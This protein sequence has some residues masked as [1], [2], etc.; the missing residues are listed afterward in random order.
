MFILR[1][2]VLLLTLTLTVFSTSDCTKYPNHSS[3][4]QKEEKEEEVVVQSESDQLLVFIDEMHDKHGFDKKYLISIFADVSKE[5]VEK[6]GNASMRAIPR[7][8]FNWYAYRDNMVNNRRTNQGIAYFKK[9]KD[10]LVEAEKRFGVPSY[11]VVSILGVETNYGTVRMRYNALEA[12]YALSFIETRR[13][14]YFKKELESFLVLSK[15][16]NQDPTLFRSSYAGA[17]GIPQFMP[18]NIEKYGIDGD[19]DGY[20]DIIN[21]HKDAIFS[22]ANYLSSYGWKKGDP[23]VEKVTL[24]SSK[25]KEYSKYFSG[26]ACKSGKQYS[27]GKLK[28]AGVIFSKSTPIDDDKKGKLLRVGIGG[29]RSEYYVVFDNLCVIMRYNNSIGYSMAVNYLGGKIANK[30]NPNTR[31]FTGYETVIKQSKK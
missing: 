26:S 7:G 2:I 3:D 18:S 20:I 22:T 14:S 31:A 16:L 5:R 4:E 13:A 27:V 19:L 30:I 24:D 1:K 11:I 23:I 17:L 8:R 12:L 10:D 28:K 25:S 29:D 21:N 15:K 6:A 9:N